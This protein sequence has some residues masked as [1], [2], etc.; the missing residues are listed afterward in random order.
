MTVHCSR[1]HNDLPW[2]LYKRFNDSIDDIDFTKD[3]RSLWPASNTDIPR[4]REGLLGAQVL[5]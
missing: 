2:Q 4:M 3:V 1:R 5:Q